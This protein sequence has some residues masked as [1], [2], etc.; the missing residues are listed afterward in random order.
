MS[1][2]DLGIPQFTDEDAAYQG[3]RFRDVVDALFRTRT[4]ACGD[5]PASRCCPSMT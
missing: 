3:S 1:T 2:F 5:E 4:S